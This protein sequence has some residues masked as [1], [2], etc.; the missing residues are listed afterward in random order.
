MNNT[1]TQQFLSDDHFPDLMTEEELVRFLR[2]PQI[3][4]AKDYHNTIENLKRYRNLPRI[5]MCNKPLYPKVAIQEW[6]KHNTESG[7]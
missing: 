1:D 7:K 3:S 2:I 5:H 6:I 4:N